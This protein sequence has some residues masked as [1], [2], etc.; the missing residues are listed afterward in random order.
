MGNP[1]RPK[2]KAIEQELSTTRIPLM[3]RNLKILSEK[4]QLLSE[5]VDAKEKEIL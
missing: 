3:R 2:D 5:R 4:V 1:A